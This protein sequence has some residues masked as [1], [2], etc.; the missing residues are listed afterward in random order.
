[1]QAPSSRGS[2]RG[3]S[4]GNGSTSSMIVDLAEDS[5]QS[6]S[7]SA[8]LKSTHSKGS[9]QPG[10]GTKG[11]SVLK[12]VKKSSKAP[13]SFFLSKVP[14]RD[15]MLPLLLSAYCS[16]KTHIF[17]YLLPSFFS[18]SLHLLPLSSPSSTSTAPSSTFLILLDLLHHSIT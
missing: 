8:A 9:A 7:C 6:T 14:K 2:G 15:V 1:M 13:S 16:T 5:D 3:S 10:L 18:L 12:E 11:K 17:L 4:I